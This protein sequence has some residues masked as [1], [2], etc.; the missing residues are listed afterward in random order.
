[1]N[2]IYKIF[3]N[4]N[5]SCNSVII[6]DIDETLISSIGEEINDVINFFNYI[7]YNNFIPM[8]ITARP[9]N[10]E[11]ITYTENQLKKFNITGYKYIYFMP[12]GYN[13]EKYKKLARKDI[14]KKGYKIEMSVGDKYWDIGKHSNVGAL[15]KYK[16]NKL[17]VRIYYIKQKNSN[18]K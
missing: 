9:N 6:F 3:N 11:S 4:I 8:I 16:K 13:V 10:K 15:V 17:N 18:K 5:R 2:N 1:M 14:I 12:R 7:K